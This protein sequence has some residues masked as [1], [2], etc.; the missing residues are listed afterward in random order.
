MDKIMKNKKGLE[1]VTN[2]SF[3][4]KTGLEKLIFWSDALNLE[5]MERKV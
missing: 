5:I 4:Y 2:L 3:N 1:L